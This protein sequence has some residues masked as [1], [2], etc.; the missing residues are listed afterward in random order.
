MFSLLLTALMACGCAGKAHLEFASLS[1][2]AIDPPAPRVSKLDLSECYWWTDDDG[3]LWIA[4]E[5]NRTAWFD[6]KL[7]LE[8]QLS[9]ALEK[10]PAGRAR[11][12]KLGPREIR[13]RIKFGLWESRFS[14]HLGVAAVYRES[15]D[16]IGRASCRE[17]V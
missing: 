2:K 16:Q 3:Q 6:R 7:R 14:S 11:N 4:M 13:T 8:F 10:L 5:K 12:Y 17:R 15:G 9:L 1:F